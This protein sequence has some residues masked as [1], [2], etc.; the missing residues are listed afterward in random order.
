LEST[1][2][3]LSDFA[4]AAATLHQLNGGNRDRKKYLLKVFRQTGDIVGNNGFSMLKRQDIKSLFAELLEHRRLSSG[5]WL[6]RE[7]GPG[8]AQKP[9]RRPLGRLSDPLL[10]QVNGS[11]LAFLPEAETQS[12]KGG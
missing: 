8:F 1:T 2:H 4:F 11:G 9:P 12:L 7:L 10:A 3:S 5:C 6:A